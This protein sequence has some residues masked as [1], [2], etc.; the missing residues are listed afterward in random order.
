MEIKQSQEGFIDIHSH[1]LPMVDDGAGSMQQAVHMLKIAAQEGISKIILT[2]HQKADCRCV[3]PEGILRRMDVLQQQ[4]ADENIPI[5]LYPGNE[6][7]YRHGTVQLLEAGKMMTLSGSH[8]VLV[9]FL[10]GQDYGYIRNALEELVSYGYRAVVAHVERYV[11]VVKDLKY[12]IRLLDMGCYFQ[13][14]TAS[15]TGDNGFESKQTVRRLLKE[16]MVHFVGTDAH[17]DGRRS[18]KI[19]RCSEVLEK[20]YGAETAG[21]L[22]RRNQE[23]VLA[24]EII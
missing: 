13:V 7:L 2:P 15:V 6:I 17:S 5:Q 18:P 16:N 8:Y 11:N 9:E 12:A 20:K 22:L 24:D 4:L 21:R 1:I 3:T 23:K 19:R 10:P 14:N